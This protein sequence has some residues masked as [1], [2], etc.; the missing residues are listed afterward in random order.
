MRSSMPSFILYISCKF[1][2]KFRVLNMYYSYLSH[3]IPASNFVIQSAHY[4]PCY[5]FPQSL[6]PPLL[7]QYPLLFSHI[8]MHPL[9]SFLILVNICYHQCLPESG[10]R[11]TYY[12]VLPK[13]DIHTDRLNA[14]RTK[15]QNHCFT[16]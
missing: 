4:Y 16:A 1:A 14:Q 9:M 2:V 6:A 11:P 5:H 12:L 10:P 13:L 8:L 7:H 3:I 15:T